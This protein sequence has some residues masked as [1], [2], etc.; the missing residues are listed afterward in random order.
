MADTTNEPGGFIT[1]RDAAEPFAVP[2][3]T[4]H[5][6]GEVADAV[7]AA[8]FSLR[9]RRWREVVGRAATLPSRVVRRD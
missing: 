2:I 3:S 9:P 1:T 8:G 5:T 4:I 7:V 6:H